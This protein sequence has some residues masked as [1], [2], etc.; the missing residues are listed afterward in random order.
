MTADS[1]SFSV[2]PMAQP[3]SATGYESSNLERGR[4]SQ[5][6]VGRI[7]PESQH[8]AEHPATSG[9]SSSQHYPQQGHGLNQT[10]SSQ[11]FLHPG[12]IDPQRRSSISSTRT[13]NEGRDAPVT[14]PPIPLEILH[15]LAPENRRGEQHRG[16][17]DD[18]PPPP[19]L[20]GDD[21]R[22]LERSEGC[23]C[24]R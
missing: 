15:P 4:G 3:T 19:G 10:H 9:A 1:L 7:F 24:F 16:R 23:L 14:G 22:S 17:S 18:G 11:N 5:L 21:A 6:Q 20:R 13:T 2:S 8:R 12:V